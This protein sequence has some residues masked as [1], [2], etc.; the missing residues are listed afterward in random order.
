MKTALLVLAL[1]TGAF[2]QASRPTNADGQGL[3]I[4]LRTD[5]P[6]VHI[7]DFIHVTVVFRSPS[8]EITLWKSFRW[9]VNTGLDL[10]VRDATGKE[11]QTSLT[12]VP[13]DPFPPDRDS[14]L[15]IGGS[16]IAGFDSRIPASALFPRPGQYTIRCVYTPRLPRNFLRGRTIW[17]TEDGTT[18]SP[19]VPIQVVE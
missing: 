7:K 16:V 11:V 9:G 10:K 1:L 3:Q 14:W 4:E 6:Q 8:K 19:K 2:G 17:G 12:I 13:N 5:T 15:S 18:Q